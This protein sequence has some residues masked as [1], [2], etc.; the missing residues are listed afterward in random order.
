MYDELRIP[1]NSTVVVVSDSGC[2]NTTLARC[3]NRYYPSVAKSISLWGNDQ[4]TYSQKEL[5]DRL[6]YVSQKAF[7]FAGFIQENLVYG[8]SRAV[9]DE[10][11]I[12]ALRSACLYK[13]LAARTQS[14]FPLLWTVFL[15]IV[16]VRAEQGC[17]EAKGRGSPSPAPS[18]VP[19]WVFI[20]D[21]ST[22]SLD[23]ATVKKGFRSFGGIC[24]TY[25]CWHHLY[26]S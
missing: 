17:L 21:E 1:C 15:S 20:L 9:S 7:F 18:S 24:C 13:S 25:W 5:M 8:L 10:K 16:L 3:L 22:T 11:L 2:R 12:G 14:C 6:L 4:A 19:P 23:D 26:F